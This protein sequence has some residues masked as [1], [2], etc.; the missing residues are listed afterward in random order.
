MTNTT[1]APVSLESPILTTPTRGLNKVQFRILSDLHL[2]FY[3]TPDELLQ[4]I[5]F[6]DDDQNSYLILAGDIG[7]PVRYHKA[8][9]F[10][11]GK[12]L[13]RVHFKQRKTAGTQ[14]N[15]QYEELLNKL[16]PKFKGV[17][18]VS[19][20]HEYYYCVDNR[21]SMGDMDTVLEQICERSDVIFLQKRT[22][23]LDH[24]Y[25]HGCTLFSNV[26][27]RDSE[28]MHDTTY[29][30]N[31]DT[32]INTHVDHINWLTSA[33]KVSSELSAHKCL[34]ITHH[35]PIPNSTNHTGYY[36]NVLEMMNT[37]YPDIQP[38]DVYVCGHDHN[39]IDQHIHG[40]HVLSAPMGYNAVSQPQFVKPVYFE[41]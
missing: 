34:V 4:R 2:E 30:A 15:P 13:S 18:L 22:V 39:P 27:P 19:G 21:I 14:P 10:P 9:P 3:T 26:T 7:Y 6:T 29:V 40:T 11:G 25:I 24:I 17:I 23:I 41:L 36:T 33:L 37:K 35:L 28:K 20:N 5:I 31:R 32:I 16:R 8:V 12:T 38:P 1:N